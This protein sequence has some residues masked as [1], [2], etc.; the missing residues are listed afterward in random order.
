MIVP[1][2][3]MNKLFGSPVESNTAESSEYVPPLPPPLTI[4]CDTSTLGKRRRLNHS[5]TTLHSCD[6]L[7]AADNV[8]VDK[9]MLAKSVDWYLWSA[10][11]VM[12]NM[13]I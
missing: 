6:S 11:R 8:K 2:I 9:L 10:R 1:V 7:S 4:E 5:D 13:V 3:R 12:L